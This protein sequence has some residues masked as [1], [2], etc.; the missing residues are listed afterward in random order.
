MTMEDLLVSYG[1]LGIWVC[2]SIWQMRLL[3]QR[4]DHMAGRHAEERRRWDR[5]RAKWLTTLGRK[6][7]DHT[8]MENTEH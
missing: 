6:L 7:S 3:I 5:E 1:P 2:V 8:I 4:M